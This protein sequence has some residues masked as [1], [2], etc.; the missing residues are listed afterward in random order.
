MAG[1][2]R[3]GTLTGAAVMLQAVTIIENWLKQLNFAQQVPNSI[4]NLMEAVAAQMRKLLRDLT[5]VD[6]NIRMRTEIIDIVITI[7]VGLFRDRVLFDDRGLDAINQFDYREWLREP[8]RHQDAR[9]NSRFLTGIYDFVFAYEDGDRR[10]P[11][12]A[13][14]VAVRGALRMFFTY[15]GA[16][17]WRVRSGMGDAVFAPLYKVLS[18]RARRPT[19][20]S[21]VRFHFLHELATVDFVR[22]GRPSRHGAAFQNAA[23]RGALDGLSED[24]LDDC[25]CWPADDQRPVRRRRARRRAIRD[26]EGRRATSTP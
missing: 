16:M 13:A 20:R 4:L 21:P 5:D 23:G 26:P 6:E 2:L 22:R 1:L 15:R 17:F 7:A 12:L 8:R 10:K 19:K 3:A 25:G 9:S 24:A 18:S 11:R 14:G